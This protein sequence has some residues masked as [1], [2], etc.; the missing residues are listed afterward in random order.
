MHF[1][2]S[3]PGRNELFCQCQKGVALLLLAYFADHPSF[4]T[5]NLS[6]VQYTHYSITR[7]TN[8]NTTSVSS[9]SYARSSAVLVVCA[10]HWEAPGYP[11]LMNLFIYDLFL[12]RVC[13][14]K[15]WYWA[16]LP[17]RGWREAVVGQAWR[18][19]FDSFFPKRMGVLLVRAECYKCALLIFDE[20]YSDVANSNIQY[21]RRVR[22]VGRWLGSRRVMAV[23]L[24]ILDSAYSDSASQYQFK[25]NL[26]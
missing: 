4:Y 17:N 25:Q 13:L 18:F 5:R 8:I 16:E 22:F 26:I 1:R 12:L 24:L 6:N 20:L 9:T 10:P 19:C 7:R 11:K 2:N 14:S 3:P 15:F 21:K 23:H